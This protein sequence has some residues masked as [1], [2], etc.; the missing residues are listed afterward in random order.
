MAYEAADFVQAI[1]TRDEKSIRSWQEETL[2]V[3]GILDRL[4]AE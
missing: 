4:R 2:L 3:M 1:E